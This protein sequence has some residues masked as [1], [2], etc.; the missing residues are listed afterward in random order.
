MTD[1]IPDNLPARKITPALSPDLKSL[2]VDE[3][4]DS[5]AIRHIA[6]DPQLRAE[7]VCNLPV[8]KAAAHQKAGREGVMEVIGKRFALYPQPNRSEGEWAAWWADYVDVL[9]DLPWHALEAGMAAYVRDGKSEFMPK[10]GKLRDLAMTTPARVAL[11]YNRAKKVAE[12]EAPK[13][14][15]PLPNYEL[16]KVDVKTMA[17]EYEKKASRP[18]QRAATNLP[19]IAGKTDE[20]GLTP[21]MRALLARQRGEA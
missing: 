5:W 19:S 7:A 10:P 4:N 3:E 15:E 8:L 1:L 20:G 12:L 2:L 13:R 16:P 21:Q 6:D 18:I 11:A 17:A 14:F 9:A